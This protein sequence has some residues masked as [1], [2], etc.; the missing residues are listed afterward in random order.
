MFW[1]STGKHIAT[2]R[3]KTL[4]GRMSYDFTLEFEESQVVLQEAKM[5]QSHKMPSP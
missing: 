3:E 5:D 1:A 2:R 4:S